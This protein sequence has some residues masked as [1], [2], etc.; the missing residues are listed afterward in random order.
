MKKNFC[1]FCVCFFLS[2]QALAA[3]DNAV[4]EHALSAPDSISQ[5]IRK[6]TN[7]LVKP[8]KK[9]YDKLKVIA[10]WMATHIAYDNYRFDNGTS[11][12]ETNGYTYDILKVKTGVCRDFA[13]LFKEMAT[14]A[15]VKNVSYVSGKTYDTNVLKKKY[16]KRKNEVG[17]AWNE[18][19]IDGRHFYIDT[20][21]MSQLHIGHDEKKK[22][23]KSHLKHKREL[24]QRRRKE[25]P[26]SKNITDFY[27]DFSP[28]EEVRLRQTHHWVK[29]QDLKSFLPRRKWKN[30]RRKKETQSNAESEV[31][32]K[33]HEGKNAMHHIPSEMRLSRNADNT[34]RQAAF[35]KQLHL[36]PSQMSAENFI[37]KENVYHHLKDQKRPLPK[38]LRQKNNLHA[39]KLRSS[40]HKS[41]FP[42]QMTTTPVA[43]KISSIRN[44]IIVEED[45][46]VSFVKEN[47]PQTVDEKIISPRGEKKGSFQEKFHQAKDFL[48]KQIKNLIAFI[49]E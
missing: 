1:F 37:S 43:K 11:Y 4:L 24:K 35:S 19:V 7:Y 34:A 26:V 39:E 22:S 10:Y 17:H 32:V 36:N 14:L 48:S 49:F 29:N 46:S 18:A 20:T 47:I 21:W 44:D 31:S 2:F 23:R 41:S 6:L 25:T 16:K 30:F 13:L 5:N 28:Q 45:P 15:G 33:L 3:V 42:E 27:F 9:D 8:Y 38:T 40:V 12:E